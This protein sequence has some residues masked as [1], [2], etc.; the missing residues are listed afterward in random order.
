ML[1]RICKIMVTLAS[2]FL[3][4]EFVSDLKS[5]HRHAASNSADRDSAIAVVGHDTALALTAP[6]FPLPLVNAYEAHSSQRWL[7]IY[8]T[9]HCIGL[10]VVFQAA[11]FLHNQ[12]SKV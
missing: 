5:G 4:D 9:E 2:N 11:H 8:S 12:A 1:Y 10:A 6:L 7:E 3:V